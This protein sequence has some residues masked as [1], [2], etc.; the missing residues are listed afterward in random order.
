MTKFEDFGLQADLLKK[1]AQ[2]NFTTPTPIQTESIPVALQGRDI[3]GTAQTG[4]GK[5][6]AFGIPLISHL[7]NNITHTALVMAPTR[8][9]AWQVMDNMRKMIP[10][11]LKINMALLIGGEPMNKQIAQL[12]GNPRIVVGT[13]GRINDH[14]NR[15]LL[16][17]NN[18]HFL[19]LD[20]TDR[21]L[22]MGFGIQIDEILESAPSDR[23][24]LLFSATLPKNILK[25]SANY[26][27]DPARISMGSLNTPIAKIKQETI[28][29]SESDK[30]AQLIEQID[31][32]SGSIIVFV[33][34]K[35]GA[36]KLAKKLRSV[37]HTADAIHGDLRQ[38][39]RDQ[40]IRHFRSKKNRI[41]V[42]TDVAA[43][44][45]DIPHIEHVINY[46]LPFSP[47][48]YIHRI[49]RTARAGAEGAA[50]NFVSPD[51]GKRWRAICRLINPE[52]EKFERDEPRQKRSSNRKGF[53]KNKSS[54]SSSK[55]KR[56]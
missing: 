24:T 5:T 8:E 52:E 32:R 50:L 41:M 47:E 25:L 20:E 56:A 13:P 12:K 16:K 51:D 6:A 53:Y 35:M 30:Y 4:T 37:E 29:I 38:R 15:K 10:E 21:M 48:D 11:N 22:D 39:E 54:R 31:N 3:L 28:K 1:L 18:M 44:G 33:K 49:G 26:L 2:L 36:D 7:I 43:R 17:L 14:L 55:R 42:A 27:K 45:L 40:V 9:L 34:T 19:V 46:D 23:Q